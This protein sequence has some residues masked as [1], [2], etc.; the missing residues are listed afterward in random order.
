M[1]EWSLEGAWGAVCVRLPSCPGQL[2]LGFSLGGQQT[3]ICL[4]LWVSLFQ[5]NVILTRHSL[6]SVHF[7]C[8]GAICRAAISMGSRHGGRLPGRRCYPGSRYSFTSFLL[9]PLPEHG[10]TFSSLP[11]LMLLLLQ[12]FLYMSSCPA[13]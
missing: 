12:C 8:G 7:N 1:E 2:T 11:L 9:S 10:N 13:S 3:A 6:P 4:L 5:P